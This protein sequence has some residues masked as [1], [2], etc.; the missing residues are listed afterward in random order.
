M[1]R[2]LLSNSSNSLVIFRVNLSV[3]TPLGQDRKHE[4]LNGRVC[5]ETALDGAFHPATPTNHEVAAGHKQVSRVGP[6]LA[7]CD[8]SSGDKPPA[9]SSQGHG[10]PFGPP[11]SLP[12]VGQ[13][14]VKACR[15]M[16]VFA[17]HGLHERAVLG[18]GRGRGGQMVLEGLYA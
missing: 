5:F 18:L 13:D 12:V 6:R 4:S 15:R 10:G 16:V 2:R 3:P 9:P 17:E 8:G 11:V 7:S 14:S 1:G